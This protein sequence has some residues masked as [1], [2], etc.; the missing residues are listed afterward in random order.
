MSSAPRVRP[1]L[2]IIDD[3]DVE[4]EGL[5][6][7]LERAGYAILKA[8]DGFQGLECLKREKPDLILLDMLMPNCDGWEF[9]KRRDPAWKSIP[10]IIITGT[11]SAN[12]SWAKALGAADFLAKPFHTDEV[13]EK[14]KQHTPG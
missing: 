2:L 3:N 1:T 4:R 12:H 9:L 8:T 11:D 5:S 6:I 7:L 10:F 14:I 13:M